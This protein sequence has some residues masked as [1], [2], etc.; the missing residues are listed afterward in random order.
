MN[1]SQRRLMI[2]RLRIHRADEAQVVGNRS[3]M[4]Q[5]LAQLHPALA[6]LLELVRAAKAVSLLLVEM[7]LQV[8]ARIRL[9]VVLRQLGLGIEQVH[10]ARAAM[11]EQA[12][13]GLGLATEP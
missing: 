4:R 8:T 10:L 9:S 11:L 5:Q 2:D 3:G 13:D 6:E 1:Q 7:D 12:D